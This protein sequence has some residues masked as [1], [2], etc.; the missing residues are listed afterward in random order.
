MGANARRASTAKLSTEFLHVEG[1]TGGAGPTTV[2]RPLKPSAVFANCEGRHPNRSWTC[3]AGRRS[4]GMPTTRCSNAV[5]AGRR[6]GHSVQPPARRRIPGEGFL[7]IA[8]SPGA[9]GRLH[10]GTLV[11][12]PEADGPGTDDKSPGC[13]D[14]LFAPASHPGLWNYNQAGQSTWAF[15]PAASI[16]VEAAVSSLSE[17]SPLMPTAPMIVPS[18]S[19]TRTPPGTGMS[20]PP[21]AAAAAAMK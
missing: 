13:W 8:V 18:V 12:S 6:P 17:L 3:D 11:R 20:R 15:R 10:S 16:A 19:R 2:V 21:R 14:V 1:T 5:S 7:S 9:A 4:P